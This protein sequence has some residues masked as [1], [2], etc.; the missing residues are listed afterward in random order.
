[1]PRV[2]AVACMRICPHRI[3]ANAGTEHLVCYG[4]PGA[5]ALLYNQ[6]TSTLDAK[7]LVESPRG[8]RAIYTLLVYQKLFAK[9]TLLRTDDSVGWNVWVACLSGTFW[10]A[11]VPTFRPTKLL[12]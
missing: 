1:M 2:A 4:P 6:A 9:Q 5:L 12:K 3:P 8:A 10:A 7:L 11:T